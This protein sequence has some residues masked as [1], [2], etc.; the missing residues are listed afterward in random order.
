M[1]TARCLLLIGLALLCGLARAASSYTFRSDSYAWETTA[2]AISTW[3]KTCTSYPGDDDK[4]TITFTGGFKFTFAGTAYT[5]VRVLTNGGLQFGTDTGFFRTY[6]NTAL[7]AGTPAGSSSGCAATA[8]TWSR[9]RS[10][11]RSSARSSR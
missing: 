11:S 6:T 4:A 1:H 8:T 9:R 7:P 5:S 10:P 3:D 2:N